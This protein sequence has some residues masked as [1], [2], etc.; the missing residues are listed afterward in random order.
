MSDKPWRC[1][2]CGMWGWGIERRE[3]HYVNAHPRGVY[4]KFTVTPEILE[5]SRGGSEAFI[6]AIFPG[7]WGSRIR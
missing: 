5:A 3:V 2:D 6:P 7:R 4:P 1:P